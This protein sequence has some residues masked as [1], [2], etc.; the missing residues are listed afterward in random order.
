MKG[1]QKQLQD[2]KEKSIKLLNEEEDLCQED[3]K[4]IM[5][6]MVGA[7][8]NLKDERDRIRGELNAKDRYLKELEDEK[9]AIK[10]K[11]TNGN[12]GILSMIKRI[13]NIE[14]R[15]SYYEAEAEKKI[16][17]AKKRIEK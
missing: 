2:S 6:Y 17:E 14:D 15:T 10:K 3:M 16:Q 7:F 13:N 9:Y 12:K 8:E 5:N 11:Y 1:I 4:E